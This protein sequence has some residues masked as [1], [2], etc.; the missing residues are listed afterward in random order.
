M[1]LR[2]MSDP[3]FCDTVVMRLFGR[4]LRDAAPRLHVAVDEGEGPVVVLVHGIAS[5]SASWEATIPLLT[6]LYRVIAIDVLGFGA[7]VARPETMFTL[8]EHVAALHRTLVG[9]HLPGRF[10]LIGHSLGALI[11]ARYAAVHRRSVEH[12]ILASPPIYPHA[13][14]IQERV[15]RMRVGGY[16]AFYRYVREDKGRALGTLGRVREL[17]HVRGP[18][19]DDV[20]WQAFALSMQ[21]CIEQQTTMT[22]VAQVAVPVEI[23]YGSRDQVIVPGPVQALGVMHHVTLHEVRGADHFVRPPLAREIARL[24]R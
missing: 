8:D 9:L 21:N 13:R 12:L 23:V 4:T 7:S 5:S 18:Q 15:A 11:S 22:D 16:L 10:T 19:L 24:V 6:P 20:T 14:Y 1:G 17:L 3:R 2:W